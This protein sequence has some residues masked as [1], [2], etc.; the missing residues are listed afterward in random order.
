MDNVARAS[1]LDR[2]ALFRQAEAAVARR[3]PVAIVMGGP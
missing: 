1:A 3:L 2:G